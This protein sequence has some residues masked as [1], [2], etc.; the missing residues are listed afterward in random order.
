L[1]SAGLYIAPVQRGLGLRGGYRHRADLLLKALQREGGQKMSDDDEL[2]AHHDFSEAVGKVIMGSHP[3]GRK[4][5][6]QTML[7]WGRGLFR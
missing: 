4:L 7:A 6:A 1:R 3:A 2:T 5:L